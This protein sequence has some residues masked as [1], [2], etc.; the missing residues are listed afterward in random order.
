VSN[1]WTDLAPAWHAVGPTWAGIFEQFVYKPEPA[2]LIDG[3]DFTGDTIGQITIRRGRDSV[4]VEPSA[5]YAAVTLRSVGTAL[6]LSIGSELTVTL[7]S[8]TGARE[9]LFRGRISDVNVSITP[10]SS[11]VGQYRLTAVGP[12]AGA[13]RRQVLAG[14]RSVEKDGERAEAAIV[15]ALG[16]AIIA[17]ALF[18]PG[19][20]DLAALDSQDGGYSGLSIAQEAAASGGAVLYETRDGLIAYAD[21]D[22]RAA[23]LIADDFAVIPSAILDLDGMNTSSSLSELANR[24]LVDWDAGT[25]TEEVAESIAQ[26]GLFVRRISTVL[27]KEGDAEVR[28]I[29]LAQNLSVPVFKADVFRLLLNNAASPLLDLLL[30]VEPNDG[31]SFRQLPPVIGFTRLDAFVEGVEWS[32]DP[33]TVRLGLFASDERLSVGLVYWGRVDVALEWDDV[34]PALEWRNVGRTL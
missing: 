24:V 19:I 31:V 26:F 27:D 7:N 10:A 15:D 1:T 25:V 8:A 2:V 28:A 17:D 3:Q 33:F 30:R 34:D 32:I 14:G 21:T 16:T 5:S 9:P 20:F 23:T 6:D 18:D 13:N 12:L 11:L 29:E 4:Y 22:R